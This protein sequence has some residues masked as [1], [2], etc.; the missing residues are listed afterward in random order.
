LQPHRLTYREL[1][2]RLR[3]FGVEE[4]PG[5]GKGSE[6]ILIRRNPTT[7]KGP[8][9][10]IK[11]HGESTELGLGTINACLRR[12]TITATEFWE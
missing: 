7:G 9:Y 8:M 4:M 11:H 10:P 6:R 2:K 1:I 12:F 3:A 5:R